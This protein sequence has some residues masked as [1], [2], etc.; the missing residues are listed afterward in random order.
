MLRFLSGSI[1]NEK[2]K[3]LLQQPSLRLW[4][5][6]WVDS[7]VIALLSSQKYM[8]THVDLIIER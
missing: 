5:G 1:L 3:Y 4:T 8:L 7:P 2:L 6:E